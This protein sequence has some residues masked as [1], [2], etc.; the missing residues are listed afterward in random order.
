MRTAFFRAL[1]DLAAEDERILLVLGDLGFGVTREYAERFPDRLINAGVAE[2]NMTGLATGLA[3]SGKVVFTYSIANFPTLRCVEQIRNDACYHDANVKVVAV[4]GGYAYGSLGMTHHATEDLAI[5]RALPGLVVAAPGDPHEAEAVTR[6][7][8]RHPGPCYLRLGRAGEPDVHEGPVDLALGRSLLV[9]DGTD[10]TIVSSGGMLETAASVA[11]L[12]A[13]KNVSVRLLSMPFLAPMDVGAVQRAVQETRAL[14]TIEEHSLVGGLGSAV[15]EVL[16]DLGRTEVAL[17]RIG[18]R[19]G[20][21]PTAGNQEY[22]RGKGGLTP[23]K[24]LTSVRSF[25]DGR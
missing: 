25:F 17:K 15:A 6:I 4:G 14:V 7:V 13:T 11:R 12:L 9:R 24:I 8:A 20:F 18:L 22:L 23:E 1:V 10:L 21:S 16:C 19:P 2:Q 3:L 5:M